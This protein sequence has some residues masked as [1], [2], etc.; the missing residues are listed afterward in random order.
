MT[1]D[2]E[3]IV[4]HAYHTAEGDVLDVPGFVGSFTEG[5]VFNDIVGQESYRGEQLGEVVLRMGRLLP[6]V[7]RELHRVTALGDAV[8]VE[9]SIQGNFPGAAGDACGHSPADGSEDRRADRRLLVPARRQDRDVQLLRRVQRHVRPDGR[10][11][12]LG[13]G[14]RCA[15]G[16]ALSRLLPPPYSWRPAGSIRRASLG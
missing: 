5:G 10:D 8:A 6:D 14:S 9:L 4:R 1:H 7:H 11:A 16:R 15:R 2:N 3:A 13:I 12:R